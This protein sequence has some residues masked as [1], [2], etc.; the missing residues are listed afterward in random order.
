[1]CPVRCGSRLYMICTCCWVYIFSYYI[2]NSFSFSQSMNTSFFNKKRTVNINSL[3]KKERSAIIEKYISQIYNINLPFAV[4][5]SINLLLTVHGS[6]TIIGT[7]PMSSATFW[8]SVVVPLLWFRIIWST[9]VIYYC[10]GFLP[11]CS[12]KVIRSQPRNG[13]LAKVSGFCSYVFL[14]QNL[15]GQLVQH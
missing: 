1:M 14:A 2:H 6:C 5:S 12:L 3:K 9:A 15:E 7:T 4:L 13:H 11:A 10:C 8:Q